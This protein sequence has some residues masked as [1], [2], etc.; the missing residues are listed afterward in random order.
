MKVTC[1]I[2]IPFFD[3]KMEVS[4]PEDMA[5]GHMIPLVFSLFEEEAYEGID[6]YKDDGSL[7]DA[8]LNAREANI[9]SGMKLFLI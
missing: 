7:V 9:V 2:Q 3:Q 1:I 4:F 6:I 8:S 5:L